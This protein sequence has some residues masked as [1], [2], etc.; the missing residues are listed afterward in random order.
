MKPILFFDAEINPENGQILDIGAVDA[1]GRQFHAASVGEFTD[2]VN[3]YT[4]FGGHNILSFDLKYL[5]AAIP[6]SASTQ[7]VDTLCLSPLLFPAK[8]T[9]MTTTRLL[10]LFI[11]ILT[12]IIQI[13]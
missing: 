5:E 4:F 11:S 6:Q 13:L 3:E 9:T 2:F 8:T 12:M 7:Y 10:L 1:D